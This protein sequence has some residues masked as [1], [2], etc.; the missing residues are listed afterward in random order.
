[1]ELNPRI[2]Q[3]VTVFGGTGFVG[4]H[5][6]RALLKRGYRVKVA[7][8]RPNVSGHIMPSNWPGQVMPIQANL[9][10]P[11]S[12]ENAVQGSDAVVNLVGIL[13]ESG[14]Q[15]FDV[16]QS[17]GAGAVARSAAAAG[18]TRLVHISAIGADPNSNSDYA[19]TKAEGE[20]AVLEAV[21]TAVVFRPSIIFGPE[22]Q[23]FNRFAGM[24]RLSPVLPLVGAMTRFQPIFVGDVAEAVANAV[25]GMLRPGTVYELGGP[26][27]RTLR[28]LMELMLTI[29][30]RRRLLL[31]VPFGM[32]EPLARILQIL[33]G[34]PLTVDQVR[35]LARDN[36]VSE[37]ARQDGRT[38]E[39]IGIDPH[40]LEV[41]LPTYLWRFR[42]FGQYDARRPVGS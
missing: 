29:I 4:R 5:V 9:R 20:A 32:A 8:R 10:V 31:S 27:V 1:M 18:A 2:D 21:P 17:A 33:P 37:E 41:V 19:R 39:G 7:V 16:V 40:S 3:L 38:L 35:L 42:R 15:R 36:V 24:A 12:V 6:V 26:E 13:R 34:A 25:D 11:A 23:F 14:R 28:A 30:G 22:D